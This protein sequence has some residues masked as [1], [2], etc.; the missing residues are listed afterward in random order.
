MIDI[1]RHDDYSS[2]TSSGLFSN[3]AD[4][5][6]RSNGTWMENGGDQP[7]NIKPNIGI[8]P[9]GESIELTLR[10]SPRDVFEYKAELSCQ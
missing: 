4:R 1:E 10:F 8:I 3:S 5:T 2:A 6:Y 7:F 9:A